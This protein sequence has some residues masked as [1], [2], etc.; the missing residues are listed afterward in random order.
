[1]TSGLSWSW[2]YTP[3]QGVSPQ[4]WAW[5]PFLMPSAQPKNRAG[6]ISLQHTSRV[7]WPHPR[8]C[9]HL[10]PA[11]LSC[12]QPVSCGTLLNLSGTHTPL[13]TAHTALWSHWGWMSE[14]LSAPLSLQTPPPAPQGPPYVSPEG[15]PVVLQHIRPQAFAA[16]TPSARNSPLLLT[17]RALLSTA[18]GALFKCH[19][20]RATCSGRPAL[21]CHPL[22]GCHPLSELRHSPLGLYRDSTCY[23]LQLQIMA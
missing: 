13:L 18:S 10:L 19:L 2:L 22:A 5:P 14:S 7:R 4:P 11:N 9:H 20:F 23:A 21:L 8:L 12:P 1:M 17:H 16:P 6:Q 15:L 3:E